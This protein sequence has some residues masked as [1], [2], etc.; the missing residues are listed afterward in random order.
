MALKLSIKEF[1]DQ[2]QIPSSLTC[3]GDDRAPTLQWSDAPQNT[4]SFTMIMEDPDAPGGTWDHWIVFNIPSNINEL[5]QQ[6]PLPTDSLAGKNSWGNMNYGGPCPP[7]RSHRYFF[8]IYALDQEL[9]LPTGSNKFTIL[10][11][12]QDHILDQSTIMGHYERI[13][14]S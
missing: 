2:G 11:A 1:K 8:T 12:M 13:K 3:D 6:Q 14:K 10:K 9:N 5:S 4:V 7:D